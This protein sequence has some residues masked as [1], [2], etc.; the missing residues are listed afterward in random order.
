MISY[1]R[2]KSNNFYLFHKY[3]VTKQFVKF[4]LVG[5]SNMLID[6]SIYWLLTRMFDIYYML[7]AV[8]SFVVAVT[9]SFYMN[10]RWTFRHNGSD[11]SKQYVKFFVVNTIV[12]ILNLSSL[13]VFVDIFGFY[14][15]AVKLAAAVVFALINFSFNKF[16][17]FKVHKV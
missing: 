11:T 6:I 12:M 13:F 7:A 2:N 14:D 5:S 16:W 8:S 4:G 3:P 1:L 9:W 10:R 17:T 15:L